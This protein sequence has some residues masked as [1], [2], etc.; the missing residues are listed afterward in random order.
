MS[1]TT[2]NR[3]SSTDQLTLSQLSG[4]VT[5]RVPT[6][7]PASFSVTLLAE[8]AISVGAWLSASASAWLPSSKTSVSMPE[9][10]SVPS[11]PSTV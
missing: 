7:A 5:V 9:M 2:S 8:S 10:R 1:P 6:V 3:A 11:G 4:S